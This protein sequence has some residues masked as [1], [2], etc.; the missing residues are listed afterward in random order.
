MKT[1]SCAFFLAIMTPCHAEFSLFAEEA[2]AVVAWQQPATLSYLRTGD[3]PSSVKVKAILG[4]RSPV[5]AEADHNGAYQSQYTASVYAYRDTATS[6]RVDDKGFKIGFGGL[7][8]PNSGNANGVTSLEWNARVS[9][10]Q[11]LINEGSTSSPKFV[12]RTKDRQTL[13][14]SIY[15][16]PRLSG[17]PFD[18]PRSPVS[19][20]VAKLGVYSDHTNG[21]KTPGRLTGTQ[22]FVSA[23]VAPFGIDPDT[24]KF[25]VLGVVPTITL[26]AQYQKDFQVSGS[27]KKDS[28]KLY[29]ASL[30]V[31]FAKLEKNSRSVIPSLNLSRSI[32]ADLLTGR[33][34][35][36]RTEISLGLTF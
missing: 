18:N 34:K 9:L 20:F 15:Y 24:N 6:A 33:P 3:T 12:D 14:G 4:Y 29:V 17:T 7:W 26:S 27:R 35:S 31:A 22:G 8:A 19:Y 11:S 5:K 2:P 10:G 23:N 30:G 28:Y 36:S 13:T 1:L 16:Q 32:G 21:G 25:G